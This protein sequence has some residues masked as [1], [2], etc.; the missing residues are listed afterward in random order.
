MNAKNA[1]DRTIFDRATDWTDCICLGETQIF[2]AVDK[3]V[4]QFT[5]TNGTPHTHNPH[6]RNWL[7]TIVRKQTIEELEAKS[8]VR[9]PGVDGEP[10]DLRYK[11]VQTFLN[12][13][14]R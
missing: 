8:T 10:F 9:C 1:N 6:K 13:F 2:V 14:Q 12:A 4:A 5:A 7:L 3:R 11:R